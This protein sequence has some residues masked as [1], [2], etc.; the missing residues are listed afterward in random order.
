MAAFATRSFRLPAATGGYFADD[1]GSV[2]EAEINAVVGAGM[3]RAEAHPP[4]PGFTPTTLS[5]D[6]DPADGAVFQANS[7]AGP[8]RMRERLVHYG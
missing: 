8:L 4:T 2:F 1:A 3:P 5:P 7:K 6:G